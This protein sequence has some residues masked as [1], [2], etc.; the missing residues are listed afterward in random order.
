MEQHDEEYHCLINRL[1]ALLARHWPELTTHLDLTTASILALLMV[2]GSP[3]AVAAVPA[4]ACKLLGRVGRGF[5]TPAKI[6]G[7]VN[8]A[9]TTL[10]VP[11]IEEE[12]HMMR[13]LA[14]EACRFSR[15]A[16]KAQKKVEQLSQ[17]YVPT[18]EMSK[19]VGKV[20]AAIVYAKVG[21]PSD[22]ASAAAYAKG[23]G[24]NLKERSSGKHKGQLKITKRGPSIVRKYLYLAV[25]RLKQENAYFQ[26]WHERK[27][28]RDGGKKMRGIVGL[29]RKLAKAL[30]YVGQ[31]AVFDA[32]LLFD[33]RRLNVVEAAA[34]PV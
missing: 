30:W 31:G 19:T 18:T 20:T 16:K 4:K 34:I 1:E 25:L 21:D 22:Y 12:R 23:M 10:G 3:Q 6:N 17:A 5:L 14:V 2:Y 15:K 24:L 11:P 7:A 9:A 28:E 32:R 26:K 29:M 8:S 13:Q 33:N 27:M